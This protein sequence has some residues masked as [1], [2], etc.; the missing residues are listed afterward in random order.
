MRDFSAKIA[1]KCC[2]G[3]ARTVVAAVTVETMPKV[4]VFKTIPRSWIY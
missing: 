2:S 4:P 3:G 1:I